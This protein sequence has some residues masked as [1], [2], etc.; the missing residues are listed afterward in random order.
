MEGVAARRP[1]LGAW[2]SREGAVQAAATTGKRNARVW[3]VWICSVRG[4]RGKEEVVG[5]G[6]VVGGDCTGS[7]SVSRGRIWI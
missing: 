6:G 7:G 5:G 2:S 3:L 4:G 1:D